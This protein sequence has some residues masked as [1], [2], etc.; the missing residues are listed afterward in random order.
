LQAKKQLSMSII[1]ANVNF[2]IS[3][4]AALAAQQVLLIFTAADEPNNVHC[5]AN[6]LFKI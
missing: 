6:L 1:G 2:N 3:C 4:S 5:P